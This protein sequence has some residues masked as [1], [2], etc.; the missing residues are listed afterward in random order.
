[1]SSVTG[2]VAGQQATPPPAGRQGGGGR[3][4]APPDGPRPDQAGHGTGKLVLWG[5]LADFTRPG[6]SPRCFATSRFKRGQRA[7][8][9]MTAIDGGT[10]EP[11]Y[12]ANMVIHLNYAGQTMDIPVRWRGVGGFPAAE[13]GHQPVEQWTGVWEIPNDAMIGSFEYTVTAQDKFG[14]TAT[15]TPFPN[16]LTRFT[17]FE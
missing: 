1:L 8:F 6:V 4:A 9:R 14:R 15:F 10:G 7:G 2:S 13:Y 16:H 5:D 3:G 12:S 17:I 11:E